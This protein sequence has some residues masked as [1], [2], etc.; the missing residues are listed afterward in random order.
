MGHIFHAKGLTDEAAA[1]FQ[2]AIQVD[3]HCCGA[4]DSLGIVLKDKMKIDEAVLCFRK[5]IQLN[6]QSVGSYISLGNVLQAKGLT[7]EAISCF[8]KALH[9]SPG[10]A[11]AHYNLS[12]ALLQSGNFREGW[13]KY[14]WRREIEGLSYLQPGFSQ[15]L[16]D[17]SDMR[18]GTVL[19]LGEQGFGDIIQFVRYVP[20][21][22][23]RNA[24]VIVCCHKELKSL[25]QNMDGVQETVAYGDQLPG[26]DVYI[27][28]LS[29]PFIFLA[30]TGDIPASVPYL[31]ADPVL[32]EKW[33]R[34]IHSRVA[35]FK[36]RPCLVGESQK[37]QSLLQILSAE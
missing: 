21:V 5:A 3:P 33:R 9:L 11:Y 25:I 20:F 16:W 36:S 18:G 13:E 23:Q 31:N 30:G 14:E 15:P 19:L 6:P 29:L 35:R 4:Y 1:C 7:G 10:N 2:R 22:V 27:P 32:K 37:R 24:K 28:L 26:F 34:K 12:L 8:Q 17:G